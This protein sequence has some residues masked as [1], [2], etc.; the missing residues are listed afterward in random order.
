MYF[1]QFLLFNNIWFVKYNNKLLFENML[2]VTRK[3]LTKQIKLIWDNIKKEEINDNDSWI[4]LCKF[5]YNNNNS[6]ISNNIILRQD[7]IL[8]GIIPFESE[9][10]LNLI[11][12][13]MNV[14]SNEKQNYNLFFE[15][16][17]K[18]Y[19]TQCLTFAHEHNSQFQKNMKKIFENDLNAMF[20]TAP[21]KTYERCLVKANTGLFHLFASF[22]CLFC[23]LIKLHILNKHYTL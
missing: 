17:C 12:L 5:K 20:A 22:V 10:D 18:F 11:E 1:K 6:N 7:S 16:N 21:V 15:H 19:L 23:F 9:K 4:K 2:S 14:T 3:Q 8:N 13:T